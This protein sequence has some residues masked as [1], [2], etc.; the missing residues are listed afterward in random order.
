[1]LQCTV[2]LGFSAAKRLMNYQ[3]KCQQL[4]GYYH[5]VEFTFTTTSSADMVADFYEL[6]K[7]LATWLDNT[8]DHT[9]ILNEKDSALGDAIHSI[10]KQR[11]YYVPFDPTSENL[12]LHLKN[13]IVPSIIPE[14]KCIK[15]RIYDTPDCW[16]EAI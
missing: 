8:L 9:A 7:S 16:V 15:V 13:E 1:M 10:T 14:P 2:K 5:L 6:K 12:A 4:H 3:G 11:I